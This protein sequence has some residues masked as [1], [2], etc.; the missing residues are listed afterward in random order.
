MLVAKWE[1]SYNEMLKVIKISI[2]IFCNIYF[3][4]IIKLFH[5]NPMVK[6]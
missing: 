5:P 1:I 6:I 2:V 3:Y 4:A